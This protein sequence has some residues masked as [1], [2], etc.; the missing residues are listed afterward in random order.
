[1]LKN[2]L[3]IA[4]RH[5]RKNFG[6]ASIMI[7]GLAVSMASCA[8]ILLWVRDE[9][10]Y[11]RFH[12]NSERIFRAY[13]VFDYDGY[14][15]EQTQTPT[16]LAATL[17]E[18]C[19]EV[20]R[21]TRVRGFRAEQI[22]KVAGRKFNEKGLG[23]ADDAFFQLFS[24]PLLEGDRRTVLAEPGTVAISE[25]AARKYFGEMPAVGR[26]LT[27][28]EKDFSVS[29]VFRDMP[30]QSHFHLDVLCSFASFP[31][32]QEANWGVNSF[33]TYLLLKK[34]ARV[35]ALAAKLKTIVKTHMFHS[36][37]EY[38]AVLAKGNS[39]TF[40][41]QALT[42]IH[43][44]SRLLW[45]FEANGSGTTVTFFFLIAVFIFLIAVINYVNLSTARSAGRAREVGIRKTV[46]SSRHS[47]VLQFLLESLL[48]SFLALLLSLAVIH[49][50]M[51]A[52]RSL[53]GKSWLEIPAV[54]DPAWFMILFAVVLLTGA[55][56]GIYPALFLSSFKPASALGGTYGR[57]VKRS[58]LRS[59]LVV[60]QFSLSILL[61]AATWIVRQQMNFIQT[62]NPGYDQEQVVVVQT[63]G[64][65]D[66]KLGVL[67]DRL[68]RQPTIVSVTASSSVPGTPFDNVGMGLEGAHS[69][70]GTNLYIADD[71]FLKTMKM[72]MAAGRFFAK[73]N[74]GDGQAVIINE[75]KARELG[76][77]DVLGKR[78]RI[79][80]GRPEKLPFQIIGIVKDFNYESFLEPV[81]PLVILKLHGACPW[82]EAC[83]AVRFRSSDARK[84]IAAIDGTWK[85]VLPGIPFEFTFLDSIY[86][87]QYR[88]ETRASRVFT[89]FTAFA[90]FVAC[91][92]LLGLASFAAEQRNR[93]IGIRKVLGA[94]VR[95]LVLMLGKE[96]VCWVALAGLIACPAAYCLMSRWLRNFAFH[97]E[98][99]IRPF[100]FSALITLAL[101]W[102]TVGYHTLKAAYA[103][104]VDSLRRE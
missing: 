89:V 99:G 96:F 55:L 103:R 94:S 7:A 102:L 68:L 28:F 91:I 65:M 18:E 85:S 92:G 16:I 35:D 84:A 10:R 97:T 82:T 14:H 76:G 49:V 88:D 9:V 36:P 48:T 19:P 98:M 57:G 83:L 21:V 8:L 90:I 5:M 25:S 69:S 43:L 54:A 86:E 13:Q 53:V 64:E 2:H 81:K 15:L 38:D 20:E 30:A 70:K 31:S 79:W 73:D 93:E 60:F 33:K 11:D 101:T 40:P 80:V 74:P 59:G 95:G 62:R 52:F 71:D 45:E 47:L 23:I 56:A 67:K 32:Y 24:F 26:V 42:A 66:G 63:F 29:G 100:L 22:V 51:P 17:K 3:K 41:L 75:S 87:A 44:N 39:T 37:A 12:E 4:L 34:G 6:Y 61:L 77:G 27:V 1:M 78:L 46:G 72:E 58:R 50:S 104:P